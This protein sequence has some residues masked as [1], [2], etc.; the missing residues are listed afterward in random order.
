MGDYTPIYISLGII[1]LVGLIVPA[2]SDSLG[3]LIPDPNSFINPIV[4]IV[5]EGV[6]FFGFSINPFSWL[7][8]GIQN[9]VLSLLIGFS[10]LPNWLNFV[11]IIFVIIGIVYTL[12]KLLPTT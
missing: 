11:L 6:G 7:G 9:Y 5:S 2:V 4:E 1:F 10:Y 8:D 3:I 12:I